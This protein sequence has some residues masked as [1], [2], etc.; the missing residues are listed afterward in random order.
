MI[1]KLKGTAQDVTTEFAIIDVGGIG[2][3]VYCPDNILTNLEIGETYS[4]YIQTY[5]RDD[6]IQLFGFDSSAQKDIFLLL[7]SVNGVGNKTALCL[8]S[9]IGLSD[10]GSAIVNGNDKLLSTIPGIGLKTA[11]R[12]ILELKNHKMF[13][14]EILFSQSGLDIDKMQDSIS[15]LVAL[16]ISKN[17]A[18]IYVSKILS[19]D[20]NTK[21]ND[22]IKEALTL[23][24][25]Q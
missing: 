2:Y 8:L 11:K 7:R 14:S 13:S 19:K 4:L 24:H 5:I 16:G 1:G 23:R 12:I 22:I 3:Q 18:G 20:P 21:I 10:L 17:Q 6:S 25:Q 9:K 15:A